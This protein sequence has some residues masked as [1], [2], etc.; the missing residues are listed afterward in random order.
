MRNGAE[1]E[2]DV[3]YG[4]GDTGVTEEE[5]TALHSAGG[6]Q[7]ERLETDLPL[8]EVE[9]EAF[10]SALATFKEFLVASLFDAVVSSLLMECEGREL[11]LRGSNGDTF[12]EIKVPLENHENIL[13][14]SIVVSIKDLY[15]LASFS[16]DHVYI[17]RDDKTYKVLFHSGEVVLDTRMIE[18]GQYAFPTHPQ[19]LKE[20]SAAHISSVLPRFLEAVKLAVRPED[21]KITVLHGRAVGD[22]IV[23]FFSAGVPS[24]DDMVLRL[25]DMRFLSRL[26]FGR[27][28]VSI[29]W[30][31]DR[32]FFVSEADGYRFSIQTNKP[33][34]DGVDVSLFEI[35]ENAASIDVEVSTIKSIVLLVSSL[36]NQIPALFFV[37]HNGGTYACFIN[38]DEV[39]SKFFLSS[40]VLGQDFRV[41]CENLHRAISILDANGVVSLY[42]LPQSLVLAQGSVQV[43]IPFR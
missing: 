22:F 28:R 29:A 18:R 30:E 3:M 9:T 13:S 11:V 24:L 25:L 32:L 37:G 10:K 21:R 36:S 34:E 7:G 31:G 40:Q 1:T 14:A 4:L 6:R 27:E 43:A 15:F 23:A 2:A 20:I 35:P 26:L 19:S 12:L 5:V 39:E 8:W 16:G 38:R 33:G 41:T 42:R 17:V